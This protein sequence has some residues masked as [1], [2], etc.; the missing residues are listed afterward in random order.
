MSN[1]LFFGIIFFSFHVD[2]EWFHNCIGVLLYMWNVVIAN[3][4][5]ITTLCVQWSSRYSMNQDALGY[6]VAILSIWSSHKIGSWPN[7]QA[8]EYMIWPKTYN[9]FVQ[10]HTFVI[11]FTTFSTHVLCTWHKHKKN[12][13]PWPNI[14]AWENIIYKN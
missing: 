7:G 10:S 3:S 5:H 12:F 9:I 4:F 13:G 1:K 2:V 11:L 6:L 8:F 14:I